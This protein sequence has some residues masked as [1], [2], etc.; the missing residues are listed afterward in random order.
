MSI[1]RHPGNRTDAAPREE[2]KLNDQDGRV[3]GQSA[4]P[5]LQIIHSEDRLEDTHRGMAGGEGLSTV[6]CRESAHFQIRARVVGDE[7]SGNTRIQHVRSASVE[8]MW[9]KA[10]VAILQ[11]QEIT[12]KFNRGIK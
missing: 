10:A 8:E 11:E 2:R 12:N 1:I 5:H 6:H 9:S 4:E 7:L 3:V